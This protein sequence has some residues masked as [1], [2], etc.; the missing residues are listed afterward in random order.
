MAIHTQKHHPTLTLTPKR[1]TTH[2]SETPAIQDAKEETLTHQVTSTTEEEDL[3]MEEID[4][5]VR[6]KAM[7]MNLHEALLH[8][9][10]NL[11]T[12]KTASMMS[13]TGTHS[14]MTWEMVEKAGHIRT[15]GLSRQRQVEVIQRRKRTTRKH[16][17]QDATLKQIQDNRRQTHQNIRSEPPRPNH[18]NNPEN[19]RHPSSPLRAN[20]PLPKRRQLNKILLPTNR[21]LNIAADR[22][23]L[24]PHLRALQPPRMPTRTPY[25][26]AT[27]LRT[28]TQLAGPFSFSALSST[29]TLLE[30]GSTIGPYT[31]ADP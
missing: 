17:Q 16:R 6:T 30:N 28:G 26:P 27:P 8:L 24:S 5:L 1:T 13:K 31:V 10:T 3:S 21:L 23:P 22:A 18:L 4:T 29:A 19:Q 9:H 15:A 7:V 14:I 2:H 20:R 11:M 25:P 12:M